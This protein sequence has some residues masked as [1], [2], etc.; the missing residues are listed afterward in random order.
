MALQ[1]TE[2]AAIITSSGAAGWAGNLLSKW[3]D[4]R[5]ATRSADRASDLKL[6]EHRDALTFQ[7]LDAARIELEG[8]RREM[9]RLRPLEGHLLH[10]EE[11]LRHLGAMLEAHTEADVMTSRRGAQAFVNRMKRLREE[12]GTI[13][14]EIQRADSLA[15]LAARGSGPDVPK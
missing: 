5:G 4:A 3:W 2:I 12:T 14:N 6:E 7:L 13:S 9:E 15:E 8:L 11:A 10:F 1:L